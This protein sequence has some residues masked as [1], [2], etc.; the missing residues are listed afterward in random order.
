M[1]NSSEEFSSSS[2]K[3]EESRDILK[4]AGVLTLSQYTASLLGLLTSIIAARLL[5]SYKFGITALLFSYPQLIF[6]FFSIKSFS[7]TTR[8]I[9]IFRKEEKK[10]ALIGICKLGFLLDFIIALIVLGI[11]S[12]TAKW[13]GIKFLHVREHWKFMWIIAS[14]FPLLSLTSTS[15]AV[16][17]SW[18]YFGKLAFFQV[19]E[20]ILQFILV[21]LLIVRGWGISGMVW[22]IVTGQALSNIVFFIYTLFFLHKHF[23]AWW[24]V[25]F[26][27]LHGY[28][29]EVVNLF[30]QNYWIVTMGSFLT[31]I[32]LLLLGNLRGP[33]EAGF[34]RI[35]Q[36]L[37]LGITYIVGA[38]NKVVYPRLSTLWAVG[39]YS[40][41]RKIIWRWS[42]RYGFPIGTILALLIF[43]LTPLLHLVLGR[44]YIPALSGIRWFLLGSVASLFFFWLN[45]LYYATGKINLWAKGYTINVFLVVILIYSIITDY[46]FIGVAI[47][48]SLTQV[49]FIIGMVILAR[50]K[51][52][53]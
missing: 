50:I 7:V 40:K 35:A 28:I 27:V 15:R 11:V 17:I 47:L 4:S 3:E 39:E 42:I 32:P 20:K 41:I 5:G 24:R 21:P 43:F 9:S 1:R 2:P 37:S 10:E 29:K 51:G 25:S 16:L 44:S 12:L 31:Q 13:V 52:L 14:V 8:Y 49:M 30:F 33:E 19:L 22:G 34:Y 6:S 38:L 26:R 23:P 53:I 36:S 18:E 48:V 45:P 46:G